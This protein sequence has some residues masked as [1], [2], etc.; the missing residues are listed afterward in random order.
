LVSAIGQL[1]FSNRARATRIDAPLLR[2]RFD[3]NAPDYFRLLEMAPFCAPAKRFIDTVRSDIV[4]AQHSRL[5]KPYCS[6]TFGHILAR[7]CQFVADRSRKLLGA[8]KC[9]LPSRHNCAILVGGW[10]DDAIVARIFF[11]DRPALSLSPAHLADHHA[12]PFRSDPESLNGSAL[13]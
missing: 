13:S 7:F 3:D 4:V 9:A 11:I 6:I 2:R 10:F 1:P 12:G 5:R 8:A